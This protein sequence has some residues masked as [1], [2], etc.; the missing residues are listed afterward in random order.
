MSFSK[1]IRTNC[2]LSILEQARQTRLNIQKLMV[3]GVLS[4]KSLI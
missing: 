1:I 4:A 2:T 3:I